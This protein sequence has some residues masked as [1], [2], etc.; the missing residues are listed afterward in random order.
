MPSPFRIIEDI[1]QAR[2]EDPKTGAVIAPP[3]MNEVSQRYASSAMCPS[4]QR[5]TAP[6][7]EKRR[8]GAHFTSIEH[9]SKFS[10]EKGFAAWSQC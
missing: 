3:L 7:H 9:G 4:R 2:L 8:V 10:W 1:I 6:L 5:S